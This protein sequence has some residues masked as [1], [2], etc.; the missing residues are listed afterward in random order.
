MREV[1]WCPALSSLMSCT[2]WLIAL[3][4]VVII[5]CEILT[6]YG[7]QVLVSRRAPLLRSMS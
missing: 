4:D 6:T 5:D 2:I 7:C 1:S 3:V